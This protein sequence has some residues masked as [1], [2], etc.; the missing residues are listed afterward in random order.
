MRTEMTIRYFRP[1][2]T[3][4]CIKDYCSYKKGNK[5]KVLRH[6]TGLPTEIKMTSNETHAIIVINDTDPFFNHWANHWK[7]HPN[8]KL[9]NKVNHLPDWM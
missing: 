1:G 3:V 8:F 9:V 4:I 2:D 5:Y 6:S 7:I